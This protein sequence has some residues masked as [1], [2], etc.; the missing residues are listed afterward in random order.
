MKKF[1]ISPVPRSDD[2]SAG[3]F[4]GGNAE[5]SER[6]LRRTAQKLLGRNRAEISLS[7]FDFFSGDARKLKNV[8]K[9]FLRSGER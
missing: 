4:Q 3:G 9:T 6:K 1:T 2:G 7:F 8:K 5:P